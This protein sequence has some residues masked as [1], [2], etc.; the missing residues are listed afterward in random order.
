MRDIA[1]KLLGT[2]QH[3]IEDMNAPAGRE[4]LAPWPM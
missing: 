4:R 3:D 1:H 2:A